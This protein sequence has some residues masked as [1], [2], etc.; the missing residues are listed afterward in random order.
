[1]QK[2]CIQQYENTP[3]VI[4]GSQFPSKLFHLRAL[5]RPYAVLVPSGSPPITPT[6]DLS[7]KQ[8]RQ[9]C[10]A[11]RIAATG[12]ASEEGRP[13]ELSLRHRRAA[14][15]IRRTSTLAGGREGE[16]SPSHCSTPGQQQ[17]KAT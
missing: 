10:A 11:R 13:M 17:D 5:Q 7:R 3:K 16:P 9:R 12:A 1:M 2:S 14:T 4:C 8:G 6:A 15:S